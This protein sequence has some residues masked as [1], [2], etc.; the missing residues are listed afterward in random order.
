MARY[1]DPVVVIGLGRFGSAL[2]LELMNRGT[3]VLAVDTNPVLVQRLSGQLSQVVTADATDP[4]SLRGLGVEDFRRAVVAIGTA[5]QASILAVATLSDLGIEDIWAKALDAQHARIL[6]RVGAH[7]VVLPEHEMGERVAHLVSG[8]MLDW[9][10]LDTRWVM[11]KTK[12][13]KFLVDVPLGTSK[14]R[15]KHHVTVVAVKPEQGQSFT[16]AGNDTV[17]SYGDEIVV[18]GHPED[19]EK[20]VETI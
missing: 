15:N 6:R 1:T 10:E 17:L 9:I 20:F 16:Y 19:V 8:H 18:A 12:P 5:Q 4:E 7:H 3:D 2:A 11:A 14:L 13:P